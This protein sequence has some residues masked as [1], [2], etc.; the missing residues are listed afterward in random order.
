MVYKISPFI[1]LR[2]SPE[3]H[4]IDSSGGPVRMSKQLLANCIMHLNIG[5][6]S[7]LA[8]HV[9]LTL[10][11]S[12]TFTTK[13]FQT[14]PSGELRPHWHIQCEYLLRLCS[15]FVHARQC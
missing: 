14:L 6:A 4:F 15:F 11:P 7:F 9:F 13:S 10:A 5:S 12:L 8:S 1:S 2:V 3:M